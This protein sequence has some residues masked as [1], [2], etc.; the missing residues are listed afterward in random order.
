MADEK[1]TDQ[2]EQSFD[3]WRASQ[4]NSEDSPDTLVA[5]KPAEPDSASDER[6]E[7]SDDIDARIE[8]ALAKE[9]AKNQREQ[10][11]L[12]AQIP[13]GTTPMFSGGVEHGNNAETWS[14]HD[15][16]LASRGEH[17]LQKDDTE[18]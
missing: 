1:D 11:A 15:Q 7:P 18:G 4:S 17:P 8:R 14:Q 13:S 2:Q 12:R 9:R 6:S 3:E 5:E 16:T 10:D